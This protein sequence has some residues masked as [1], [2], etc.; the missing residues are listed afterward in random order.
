MPVYIARVKIIFERWPVVLTGQTNFSS[1]ISRF[2][3]VKILKIL[4]LKNFPIKPKMSPH[5]HKKVLLKSINVS[6]AKSITDLNMFAN[7]ICTGSGNRLHST[8]YET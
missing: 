1:V 4:I 7:C 8:Q 6:L 3:Q 2:W 5:M